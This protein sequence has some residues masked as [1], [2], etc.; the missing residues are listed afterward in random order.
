M[1]TTDGFD[2][3]VRHHDAR[4]DAL[5]LSVWAGSEPTFTD[6]RAHTPEWLYAALGGDK[7]ARARAMLRT[8]DDRRP[9]GAVLRT[10]GR[11]YPGETQPRWSLGLYRRRDGDA[12]WHGPPDPALAPA[13]PLR[14]AVGSAAGTAAGCACVE[15]PGLP[16]VARW[17]E[18]LH[19]LERAARSAAL[20]ALVIGGQAPPVD[21]TVELTTVTPDPAVIEV[22]AAP[23]ASAT[24]FLCRSRDLYAAAAAAGLAPYRLYY[25]G[26]VAD[27]GGG[28][29]TLGGPTPERSPFWREPRLLPRLLRYFIAHPSLSY[30]FAHDH[31][32]PWG[33]SV[34]A[35]ERGPAAFDELALALA[36]LDRQRELPP[37]TVW[38]ALAP[39]LCD[40]AGNSHRADIKVEK[41]CNPHLA[42]RGRLGLVE[43]RAL[44]MQHS[45]DRAAALACLLRAVVAMLVNTPHA[46]PPLPDW[47]RELHERFALPSYLGQDLAEVLRDL[48]AAGVGLGERIEARL[49][50]DEFRHWADLSLPGCTLE[51]RRALEFWPLLGDAT[52]PEH[53]G[54]SRLVDASTSRVELRLRPGPADAAHAGD[55]PA[56]DGRGWEIHA[57]GTR[58]PLRHERDAGGELKVFGLRHRSH[59]PAGGL[60]PTLGAQ[61]PVELTLRHPDLGPSFAVTLHEWRPDGLAYDGVPAGLDDARQRRSARVTLHEH[62]SGPG[63]GQCRGAAQACAATAG[64]PSVPGLGAFCLDLRHPR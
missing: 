20:P 29:I 16:T 15:L 13:E 54:T 49:A 26:T 14:F 61:A 55:A 57:G 4:I 3:A 33:Q 18:V 17:L 24:E 34:R 30:L 53:A 56:V 7:E 21:E 10:V 39:F 48:R 47:G 41:L 59:V 1:S 46:A 12:L 22:N 25:N 38:Q 23:S 2:E 64:Q 35:D 11:R 32:G 37:S 8:L 51:L 43:F 28:Q 62:P 60:H 44:R 9:G 36:L 58:L 40:A 27:S 45:P 42:G 19:D 31:V 5:G 63:D 50:R 6:R 52:A